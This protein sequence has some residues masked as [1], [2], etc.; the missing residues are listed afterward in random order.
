MSKKLYVGNLKWETTSDD[1]GQFFA[2]AGEVISA[3]VILDRDTG[4]SRGFGFVEMATEEA[5]KTALALD[6][7][8][9]DGRNV[10]VNEA[11]P[12]RSAARSREAPK[13]SDPRNIE[14]GRDT[15]Q[16]G[17]NAFMKVIKK[18]V[19]VAEAGE[20]IGFTSDNKHF[21]IVRD[22]EDKDRGNGSKDKGG[23]TDFGTP[24][25]A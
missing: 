10:V 1:L 7:Q 4:R 18:F 6:G 11:A 19:K 5:A 2:Q 15:Y 23:G 24:A 25:F 12:E 17:E 13:P 22:D 20:E 3:L 9:F 8:D 21:T 14:R 16:Q